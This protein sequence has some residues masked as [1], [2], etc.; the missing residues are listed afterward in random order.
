MGTTNT[1]ASEA[2]G[3]SVTLS[4][5]APFEPL[6]SS[7]T[8]VVGNAGGV[9]V[10]TSIPGIGVSLSHLFSTFHTTLY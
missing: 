7:W 10:V 5:V 3:N 1:P 2:S 6:L 9:A 4:P 8:P